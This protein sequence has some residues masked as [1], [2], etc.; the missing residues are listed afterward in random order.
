MEAFKNWL[1]GNCPKKLTEARREMD[2]LYQ[3]VNS[4]HST[5]S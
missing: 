3:I 5:P 2:E 4:Y 1:T